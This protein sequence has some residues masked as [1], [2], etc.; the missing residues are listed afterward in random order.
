MAACKSPKWAA[1]VL[2]ALQ[3]FA[4]HHPDEL[5]EQL[6]SLRPH[7]APGRRKCSRLRYREGMR[8][9]DDLLAAEYVLLPI[10]GC[11]MWQ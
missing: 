11:D 4:E 2:R 9:D 5:R 6:P 8:G 3:L 7:A 1:S 10:K